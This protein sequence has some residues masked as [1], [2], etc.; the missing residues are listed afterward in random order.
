LT[1]EKFLKREIISAVKNQQKVMLMRNFLPQ[2]LESTYLPIYNMAEAMPKQ[3]RR[4][5]Q[6]LKLLLLFMSL[7]S[8]A[9]GYQHKELR[10]M[11]Q[12]DYCLKLFSAARAA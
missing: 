9:D 7:Y 6:S 3:T 4:A 8:Q 11:R 1:C 2:V 10:R 5:S 12:R